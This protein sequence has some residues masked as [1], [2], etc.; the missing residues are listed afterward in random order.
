MKTDP[1]KWADVSV[2]DRVILKGK[3]WTVSAIVVEGKIARVTIAGRTKDFPK[4]EVVEVVRW[5]P[6]DFG[7]LAD[8]AEKARKPKKPRTTPGEK[9]TEPQGKVEKRIAKV[10]SGTLVGVAE[11]G[12]TYIVPLLDPSTIAG[13]LL[14]FHGLT[15]DGRYYAKALAIHDD[16]HARFERGDLGLHV[17][18]WHEKRRPA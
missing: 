10:L 5:K 16:E 11:D 1:K 2:D 14:T 13:H 9:W 17:P 7:K 15:L 18:H 4:K 8:K 6:I 3:P 12:E